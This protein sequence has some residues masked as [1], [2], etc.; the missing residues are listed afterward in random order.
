MTKAV[1]NIMKCEHC[2]KNLRKGIDKI[3]TVRSIET[4]DFGRTFYICGKCI[5]DYGK[6]E[7]AQA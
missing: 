3:Y 4:E 6:S 1:T 2:K 7:V 5:K